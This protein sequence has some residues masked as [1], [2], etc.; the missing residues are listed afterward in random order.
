MNITFDRKEIK[1][2]PSHPGEILKELY[3]NEIDGLSQQK[4]ANAIGVSFRTINMICNRKRAVSASMAVKLGV[5][6]KTSAEMW[7]DLQVKYDL[8]NAKQE[9]DVSHIQPMAV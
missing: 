5:Y 3:I 8:W 1:R 2:Q 7:L 9:T 6:F 4:L